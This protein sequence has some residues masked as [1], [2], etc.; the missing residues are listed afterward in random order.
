MII[1]VKV[2]FVLLL[3]P[4]DPL[5]IK[6]KFLEKLCPRYS[7]ADKLSAGTALKIEINAPS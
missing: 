3:K 6:V 5:A 7:N 4:P 1:P 2:G